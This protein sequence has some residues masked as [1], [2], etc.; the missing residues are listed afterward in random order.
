MLCCC[1]GVNSSLT[2]FG[3]VVFLEPGLFVLGAHIFSET[4]TEK[5]S[6]KSLNIRV[7]DKYPKCIVK[8]IIIM[9][10]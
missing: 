3:F 1:T 8:G 10:T 9:S 2:G 4:G 6:C 7:S 5:H